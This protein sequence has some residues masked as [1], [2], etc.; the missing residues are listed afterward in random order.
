MQIQSASEIIERIKEAHAAHADGVL[1]F[2]GDGTLWS[3]DVGEDM[4][5]AL[6]AHKDFRAEAH[7][8]MK[9]DAREHGLSDDGDGVHVAERIYADYL[10]GRFPE[11]RICELMAWCC[12][13]WTRDEV[14]AFAARTVA[15]GVL[16]PRFHPEAL[17][18]LRWA[19]K[20]NLQVFLVSASPR[21]I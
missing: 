2:D 9:E 4:F 10:A 17:R 16:D 13:E 7:A 19:Q 5:H 18:V 20:E 14:A 12:A 21:P 6:L 1:A 3:G 11:E 15:G 8:Q